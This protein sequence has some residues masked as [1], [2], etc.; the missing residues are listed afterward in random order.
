M[1]RTIL[2]GLTAGLLLAGCGRELSQNEPAAGA[3][4][5]WVIGE[6]LRHENLTIFPVASK[7]PRTED[8]FIT[9]D[10]GLKAGTVEIRERGGGGQPSDN[11]QPNAPASQ[12]DRDPVET[13]PPRNDAGQSTPAPQQTQAGQTEQSELADSEGAD[14][15]EVIVINRS[16]KPLYLGPGDVMIGGQQDRVIGQEI[17]VEATGKPT[18]IR[19]FCV[20][21]GRWSQRDVAQN[22]QLPGH[23]RRQRG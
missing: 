19:V 5:D 12:G 10:E 8:R 9:L 16:T 21:H 1:S 23:R 15:N 11:P 13:T 20:E 14:V 18:P 6:P 4:G 3:Y 17:I 2:V 22:V 7:T